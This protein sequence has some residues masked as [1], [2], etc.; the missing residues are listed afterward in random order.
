MSLKQLVAKLLGKK[1]LENLKQISVE[2]FLKEH[3]EECNSCV[4]DVRSPEEH[5][6]CHVEGVRL[7]PLPDLDV[8]HVLKECGDSDGP[9]YVLCKA[10]G[11]AMKAAEQMAPHTTRDVVVVTGGTD[12]CVAA[13][14][15]TR[16]L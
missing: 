10:G 9:I 6:A 16:T 4:I 11:R 7:F 8:P 5:A 12:A 2:E 3:G 1:T 14:A 13:G 15:K